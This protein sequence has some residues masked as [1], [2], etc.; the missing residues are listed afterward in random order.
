MDFLDTCGHNGITLNSNKF[1]FARSTAEFAGFDI[2]PTKVRPC[3]RFLEAIQTFPTPRN[4]TD[5]RSWFG[6]VNQVSYAFASAERMLPFRNLLKPGTRFM[7]TE[8]LDQLFRESKSLI[9]DK[10]H[11][12]GGNL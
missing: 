1:A 11:K 5:I 8:Q 4:I 9:I 6:L 2:T 7:W 10:I 12:R 3:P